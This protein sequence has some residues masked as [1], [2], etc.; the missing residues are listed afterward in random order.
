MLQDS[1][2]ISSYF[3]KPELIQKICFQTIIQEEWSHCKELVW[4]LIDSPYEGTHKG[5]QLKG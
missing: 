5:M 4:G 2:S 3:K 1:N